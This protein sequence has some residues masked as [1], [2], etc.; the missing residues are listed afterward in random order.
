[1]HTY[2]RE[3]H[4][5]S[6][7]KVERRSILNELCAR[8]SALLA[9]DY[10]TLAGRT[11]IRR[12]HKDRPALEI[13]LVNNQSFRRDYPGDSLV[14]VATKLR[15]DIFDVLPYHYSQLVDIDL[16][17]GLSIVAKEKIESAPYWKQIFITFSR[18][19][20]H[21]R[22]KG[23]INPKEDP[24]YFMEMWCKRNN[25]QPPLMP[26]NPYRHPNKNAIMGL[27]DKRG[28]EYW[29]FLLER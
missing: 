3:E 14:G 10:P 26:Q 2:E 27:I 18:T 17:G 24:A 1:M 7:W 8:N 6:R 5:K 4:D 21:Q 29:T 22:L 13:T 28:P 23:A 19:F 25:W 20:R 16:F 11:Y 15:K 9:T 12:L